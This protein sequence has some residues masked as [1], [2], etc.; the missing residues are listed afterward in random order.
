MSRMKTE[1]IW[2]V[3]V[4]TNARTSRDAASF[5][6]THDGVWATAG[7]HPE[8][9]TSAYVDE[10]E[11]EPGEFKIEEIAKVAQSSKKIV[12][13][14]ET[15]LDFFRIDADRDPESA[16]EMQVNALR[17]HIALAHEL[18]LPLVI[19]CR[20]AF[21]ELA[22]ILSEERAAGTAPRGVVHC[23]TG[24][25][26]DAEPL[27]DLGCLLSFTGIITFQKKSLPESLPTS[28]PLGQE[29]PSQSLPLGQGE[30]RRGST[31]IHHVIKNM[32]ADRMMVE[33]DAPWLAPVPHRGQENEP[34]YVRYVAEKIA[35]IRG[36][37]VDE[38]AKATTVNARAFFNI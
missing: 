13:I 12:A 33:T 28:L 23:F 38:I 36:T 31:D 30:V 24:N 37:S 20:N 6:E 8:H 15:G 10:R 18:K 14:G 1:G 34:A 35:E 4:G 2:T 21:R 29:N 3:T 22:R 9:L 5:A 27:L 32:P 26:A 25:W 17:E 16:K 19:H 7:Y 11:G